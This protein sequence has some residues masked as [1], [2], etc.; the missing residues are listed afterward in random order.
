MDVLSLSAYPAGAYL[1]NSAGVG[2]RPAFLQE[3]GRE[4]FGQPTA[5]PPS[6]FA[7]K[8]RIVM[9]RPVVIGLG[10]LIVIILLVAYFF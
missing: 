9:G 7:S 1:G 4:P 3:L 8:E 10:T 5:D 2:R 6:N